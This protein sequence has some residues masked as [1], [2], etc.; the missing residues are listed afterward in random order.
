MTYGV[1]VAWVADG[2]VHRFDV[3]SAVVAQLAEEV[4]RVRAAV[5]DS[6]AERQARAAQELQAEEEAAEDQARERAAEWA[7][8]IGT[9]EAFGNARNWSTRS[10]A[11]I[12]VVPELDTLFSGDWRDQRQAR[13]VI[14]L[15][16]AYYTESV[17]P[18]KERAMAAEAR[19]LLAA[20]EKKGATAARLGITYQTL[21]R[22]LAQYDG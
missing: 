3:Q 5:N 8:L 7:V 14:E 20:G 15:A 4:D 21:A 19:R 6:T 10:A 17:L 9:D 11:A 12:R 2:V 18:V 1:S 22:L 16:L 13:D